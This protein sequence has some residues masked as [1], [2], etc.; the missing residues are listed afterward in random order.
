MHSS[1]LRPLASTLCAALLFL[2]LPGNVRAQDDAETDNSA[3]DEL[4][5]RIDALEQQNQVLMQSLRQRSQGPIIQ[6][7]GADLEGPLGNEELSGERL[8]SVQQDLQAPP[9]MQTQDTAPQGPGSGPL[10]TGRFGRGFVNNGLWFESQ[11][12]A[13]R[14]HIGGRTQYDTAF[15]EAP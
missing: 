5:A 2:A 1:F 6:V 8:Q 11:D 10:M 12:K 7:G 13:F 9:D 4:R 15:F 3:I 14:V